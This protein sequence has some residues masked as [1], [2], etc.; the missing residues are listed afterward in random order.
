MVDRVLMNL[1]PSFQ[2]MAAFLDRP[3]SRKESDLLIGHIEERS[4]VAEEQ[5]RCDRVVLQGRTETV[6]GASSGMLRGH[7]SREVRHR[8]GVGIVARQ[9]ILGAIA[10]RLLP[11]R[12]TGGRPEVDRRSTKRT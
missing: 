4:A 12:E 8:T 3:W 5:L 7:P 1:H 9:G 10:P 11:R 2:R 6:P